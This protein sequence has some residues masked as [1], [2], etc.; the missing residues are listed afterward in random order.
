[1]VRRIPMTQRGSLF[2][3]ISSIRERIEKSSLE[4]A[5]NLALFLLKSTVDDAAVPSRTDSALQEAFERVRLIRTA[6]DEIHS[7]AAVARA[8]ILRRSDSSNSSFILPDLSMDMKSLLED[9]DV[10]ESA[11]VGVLEAEAA[12]AEVSIERLQSAHHSLADAMAN[13]FPNFVDLIDRT[14][15]YCDVLESISHLPRGPIEPTLFEIIADPLCT[16]G[17]LCAPMGISISG[18]EL[19]F[20]PV[21]SSFQLETRWLELVLLNT[22]PALCDLARD[23]LF[24]SITKS[25]FVDVDFVVPATGLCGEVAFVKPIPIQVTCRGHTVHMGLY[26]HDIFTMFAGAEIRLRNI[27]VAGASLVLPPDLVSP[28]RLPDR[29]TCVPQTFDCTSLTI[30]GVVS[31][32]FSSTG[33][34]FVP[35]PRNGNVKTFYV[36]GSKNLLADNQDFSHGTYGM[37]NAIASCQPVAN[38]V[39]FA[40]QVCSS[41]A[42]ELSFVAFSTQ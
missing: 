1:M 11:K 13:D 24:N 8:A 35:V 31:P 22:D 17:R 34:I 20:P 15:A 12:R 19:H 38:V 7:K 29:T 33:F 4:D 28:L 27:S 32:A 16:S 6:R 23:A 5:L 36:H 37:V 42:L 21:E 10:A 41:N 9:I 2:R 3:E 14:H 40:S 39:I 25:L 26:R 30:A 18:V